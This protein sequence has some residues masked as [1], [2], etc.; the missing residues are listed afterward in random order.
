MDLGPEGIGG[1]NH[2]AQ[3]MRFAEQQ[4]QGLAICDPTRREPEAAVR[5]VV[6]KQNGPSAVEEQNGVGDGSKYADEASA[7]GLP[8]API[9]ADPARELIELVCER[10]EFI[11]ARDG[12][13]DIALPYGELFDA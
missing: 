3:R 13:T 7:F 4:C 11:V 5:L 9:S 10:A 8:L 1:G 6:R 12:N 2:V